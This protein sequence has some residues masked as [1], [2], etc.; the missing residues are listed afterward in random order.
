MN[1]QE[2][3]D[4][5]NTISS[6]QQVMNTYIIGQERLI[7]YSII[8]LFSGGHVLLE[9][10]PGIGKTLLVKTLSSLIDWDH[11]RISFTPDLLPSDLIGVEIFRPN[12]GNFEIRKWPIFTNILLADEINRTPPKVQS[13]LL[14]A[15]GEKRVT[16]GNTTFELPE[17][18]FVFATQNPLEHEG[19]YPLP[20]AQLDRFMMKLEVDYPSIEDEIKILQMNREKFEAASSILSQNEIKKITSEISQSVSVSQEIYNYIG[21]LLHFLRQLTKTDILFW[22]EYPLLSYWPS[23]RSGQQLLAACKVRA[24]IYWRD[25]IEPEDIKHLLIPIYQ[26]RIGLSYESQINNITIW[27]ILSKTLQ[28]VSI[29]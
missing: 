11:S 1:T 8:A 7:E 9:W 26:H 5:Q 27:S 23:T 2:I 22:N 18:F 13:A 16:I 4:I 21:R 29:L 3:T 19:T 10:P 12:T 17:V 24:A 28:T 15:M 20:E 6:L 25:Y 14:E